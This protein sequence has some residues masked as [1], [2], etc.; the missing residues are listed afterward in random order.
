MIVII[1]FLS[2]MPPYILGINVCT[3]P[4]QQPGYFTI[5]LSTADVQSRVSTFLKTEHRS[6]P[7]CY[8]HSAQS[9]QDPGAGKFF[10]WRFRVWYPMSVW[11]WTQ[12][13]TFE[14]PHGQ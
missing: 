9:Q 10:E 4:Q 3:G 14:S 7:T 13:K 1:L 11:T 6:T 2:V 12:E 5:P 8:V